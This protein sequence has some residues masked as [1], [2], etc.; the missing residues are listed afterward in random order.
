VIIS[1]LREMA[2]SAARS[3]AVAPMQIDALFAAYIVL[4]WLAPAMA[5]GRMSSAGRR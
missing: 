3:A 5:A 1:E 2:T 4:L